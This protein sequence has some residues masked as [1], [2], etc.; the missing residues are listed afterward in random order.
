MSAAPTGSSSACLKLQGTT[1]AYN[2]AGEIKRDLKIV[3]LKTAV[4]E[5]NFDWTFA[6]I[7]TDEAIRGLGECFFAKIRATF[8]VCSANFSLQRLA[9]VRWR[10]SSTTRSAASKPRSGMCLANGS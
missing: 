3:R 10:G 7:E 5:G 9:P 8:I 6:R 4:V 1:K 2:P